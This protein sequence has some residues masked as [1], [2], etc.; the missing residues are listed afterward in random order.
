MSNM[1]DSQQ[2]NRKNGPRMRG[3]KRLILQVVGWILIALAI[4]TWSKILPGTLHDFEGFGIELGIVM[5][6]IGVF[7][8]LY[9][10]GAVFL[11]LALGEK[12]RF[13]W[14]AVTVGVILLVTIA[15]TA[16][17]HAKPA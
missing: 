3:T 7:A 6:Y 4:L 9:L 5:G 1:H 14:A 11:I 12:S 16:W 8:L 15:A 2:S 13:A 17:M 10:L